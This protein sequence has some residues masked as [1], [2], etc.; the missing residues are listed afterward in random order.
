MFLFKWPCRFPIL[1]FPFLQT[2]GSR[3]L[4]RCSD[5]G[6]KCNMNWDF[7]QRVLQT[8]V[9]LG[10]GGRL[11]LSLGFTY[12]LQTLSLFLVRNLGKDLWF[13]HPHSIHLGRSIW[14]SYK[15][16]VRFWE[17]LAVSSRL[18]GEAGMKRSHKYRFH[19]RGE[20]RLL[21]VDAWSRSQG[22]T[23]IISQWSSF[24]GSA[25]ASLKIKN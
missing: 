15:S 13:S 9:G 3:Q 25:I 1:P 5:I 8:F 19:Q 14:L 12:Y 16:V 6:T 7:R 11:S 2:P 24:T 18:S 10:K 17:H 21:M 4:N 22:V 23:E 20:G